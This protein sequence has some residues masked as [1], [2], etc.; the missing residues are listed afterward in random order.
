MCD[1]HIVQLKWA[2]FLEAIQDGSIPPFD[3][4]WEDVP[5]FVNCSDDCTFHEDTGYAL[6]ATECYVK[7][8][9]KFP[10]D[11]LPSL[12]LFVGGTFWNCDVKIKKSQPPL[13]PTTRINPEDAKKHRIKN[14]WSLLSNESVA[15][16]AEALKEIK[17]S[18]LKKSFK[19]VLGQLD[20][21]ALLDL[22]GDFD[23]LEELVDYIG[24]WGKLITRTAKLN[25]GLL[26][27]VPV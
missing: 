19:E 7:A 14:L 18:S 26:I 23:S 9:R 20:E 6:F 21:D 12:D 22:L 11:W 1:F 3:D 5:Y 27:V 10:S 13:T 8:R 17:L 16:M 25:Y 2:V 15:R 24:R 4:G